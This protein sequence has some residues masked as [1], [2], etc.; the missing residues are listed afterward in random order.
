M[1][2]QED[3]LLIEKEVGYG[4]KAEVITN[5]GGVALQVSGEY[6]GENVSGRVYFTHEEYKELEKDKHDI[7]KF[8]ILAGRKFDSKLGGKYFK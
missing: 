8:A 3:L 7:R 1:I 4:A 5:C 2:T 6:D